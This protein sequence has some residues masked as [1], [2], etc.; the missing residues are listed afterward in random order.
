MACANFYCANRI[1]EE[2]K[3]WSC[4]QLIYCSQGCMTQDWITYHQF[5]C[6]YAQKLSLNDF[7]EVHDISLKIL[8]KG[9]YGEVRLYKQKST[10]HLFAIKEI[11]K[12]LVKKHSSVISLLREINIHKILHHHNIIQLPRHFENEKSVFLLLEYAPNGNLYKLIRQKQGLSEEKAWKFF[13]QTCIGLKYLHDNGIIHRDLKPENLLLDKENNIKICD[14][15]WCVQTKEIRKTFCGT[16]DYM[17]PEMLENK[18]HFFEVDLW[19]MGVLLYELIHGYPPFRATKDSE[20][21]QQILSREIIFGSFV[22]AAAKDL[23]LKLVRVDPSKRL[24]LNKILVHPWIMKYAP[25]S[26]YSENMKIRHKEKGVGVITDITG[27]LCTVFYSDLNLYQ[28]YA[29]PDLP[30]LIEIIFDDPERPLNSLRKLK[31]MAATPRKMKRK[32]TKSIQC[33]E[34]VMNRFK[35]E[36]Y[37]NRKVESSEN[38]TKNANVEKNL[39]IK[40]INTNESVNSQQNDSIRSTL[41]TSVIAL[42]EKEQELR[43]LTWSIE[44]NSIKK[45]KSESLTETRKSGYF[46]YFAQLFWCSQRK[47]A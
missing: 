16:L 46:D 32:R 18:G 39:K 17:A 35:E 27:L 3:C 7:C 44:N 15:G 34:D 26:G 43:R 40:R 23:I 31:T 47:T 1:I 11:R 41:D 13:S 12:K 29:V 38:F 20:K 10:S 19:A 25:N 36:G 4:E 37:M 5:T 45:K 33:F 21:C 24:K 8:G 2:F 22:S 42:Q 14:F 9:S 30:F 28:Y 6:R